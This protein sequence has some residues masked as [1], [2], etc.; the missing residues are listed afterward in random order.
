MLKILLIEADHLLARQIAQSLGRR[1]HQVEWQVNPQKA[2]ASADKTLPD[3]IILDMLLAGHG[4]LE[5]LFELRSYPEWQGLPIIIYSQVAQVDF[6]ETAIGL[7]QLNIAAF[8]HKPATSLKEL[9]VS[10]DQVLRSQP[11]AG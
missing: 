6:E 9:A 5:F 7:E 10:V 3:L 1:G 8:L 11:V 2:M 4:G